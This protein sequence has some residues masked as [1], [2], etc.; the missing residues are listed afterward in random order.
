MENIEKVIMD[1]EYIQDLVKAMIFELTNKNPLVL[2]EM[3][4]DNDPVLNGEVV[5]VDEL[6]ELPWC[7]YIDDTYYSMATVQEVKGDKITVLLQDDDCGVFP[8]FQDLQ[9]INL[10]FQQQ[11]EVLKLLNKR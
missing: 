8:T 3:N 10:D 7:D 5:T 9:L 4:D 11:I 1:G 6:L 2:F